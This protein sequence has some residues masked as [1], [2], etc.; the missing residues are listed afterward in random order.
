VLVGDNLA[1]HLSLD[2]ITACRDNNIEFVCLPAHS[3]DK[4]QPLD[5]GFFGP[6][7]QYWRQILRSHRKADP[8][9]KLLDKKLFPR[10]IKAWFDGFLK[11]LPVPVPGY[12]YSTSKTQNYRYFSQA[13]FK[14][15]QKTDWYRT[16]T[17]LFQAFLK[18][19][20]KNVY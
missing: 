3:T 13:I 11:K 14:K 8:A 4:I 9:A 17:K 5:V 18:K 10:K 15:F 19:N 1:S 2:V 6:M 16:R 20:K 7:K 12:R